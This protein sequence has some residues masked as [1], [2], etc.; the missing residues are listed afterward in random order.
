MPRRTMSPA[1]RNFGSGF[2]PRATPGGVP[3]IITSPG[4]MTKNCEQCQTR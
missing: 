4:S 3:V 2:I 1:L